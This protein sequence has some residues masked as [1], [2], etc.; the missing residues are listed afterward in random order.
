[1]LLFA[2]LSLGAIQGEES[3]LPFSIKITEEKMDKLPDYTK[4]PR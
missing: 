3:S 1:V 2:G 4:E